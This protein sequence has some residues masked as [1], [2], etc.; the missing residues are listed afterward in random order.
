MADAH[1]DTWEQ[2]KKPFIKKTHVI[3]FLKEAVSGAEHKSLN[4]NNAALITTPHYRVF[5]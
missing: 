3:R 5:C 4:K 2:W 1:T